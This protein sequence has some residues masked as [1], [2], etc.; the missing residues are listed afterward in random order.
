M[1]AQ[2]FL[3][4]VV[5][6]PQGLTGSPFSNLDTS[7]IKMDNTSCG[8]VSVNDGVSRNVYLPDLKSACFRMT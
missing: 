6:F 1:R 5:A 7:S 2:A 8:P 3:L 4:L